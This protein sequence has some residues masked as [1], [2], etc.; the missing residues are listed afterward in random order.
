MDIVVQT[1]VTQVTVYPDR[2]RVSVSG[3]TEV[4]AGMHQLRVD[5]LP[6]A[7]ETDSIRVTGQGTA[8]VRILSVDVARQHYT[9][10]P[11]EKVR[12]LE[13]QIEKLEDEL[14]AIK[15]GKAGWLAH[16]KYLDGLRQS[17]AEYARGLARGRIGVDD[18]TAL[19]GFLQTQDEQMR[20]AVRELDLQQRDLSR[21]VEKLRRELKEVQS[22]RPRQRFQARVDV[23]VQTAG[24]FQLV[25]TYV[26]GSAGWQPLYDIRLQ[27]GQNG[28]ADSLAFSYIAQVQQN[29]GQNWQG[30]KLAVST[31]R[32]A[33][34][35]RLPDLHPW[36]IDERRA[37]TPRPM[38]AK[39]A[40]PAP[41]EDMAVG[42]LRTAMAAP[43]VEEVVEAEVAVA[44]VQDSGTAV[45]FA[46]AGQV[47]IPSD[48]SPHKTTI[49]QFHFAPQLDY[50]AV[51]KHTDAVYRRAKMVND[52]P[53]PLL[54]GPANLFVGDEFIGK[55]RL[56]YTPTGG[57][58]EL[59]LGVE[60][61]ITITRELARRD[62]DKRLL[63]DNRQL[64]YGYEIEVKNL[65]PTA[66]KLEIHDHIPVARHEQIKVKLEEAEPQPSEKSDLNL[67][68]W[69][70][71]LPAGAEKTVTYT[72]SVEHPRS[73]MVMGLID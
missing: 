38:R 64:R 5:E 63:R 9:E 67:L 32:P 51:P 13:Q 70:F 71:A 33:L 21:E 72:F 8:V 19:I 3:E 55:T 62:V 20:A 11:V 6:L 25:L 37:P 40:A 7:M 73:M 41:M 39:M 43:E 24:T 53:S 54:D 60:E 30:V 18:Q 49:N 68:E 65:L 29:T 23:E 52:S 46:I 36:Y 27:T 58:V 48:G 42:A 66:A 16:A 57:E 35:Q 31:A 50:L 14:Q 2:A 56:Q 15:D 69:R 61:R 26:V 17:T 34:N 22:A 1:Q 47:D 45:S 28:T 59:L 12:Q 44:E 4:A 10:A